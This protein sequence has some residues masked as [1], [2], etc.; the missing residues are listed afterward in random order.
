MDLRNNFIRTKL[1]F[2]E[3]ESGPKDCKLDGD[4]VKFVT[5]T[6]KGF[7]A[8]TRDNWVYSLPTRIGQLPKINV[9]NLVSG[10]EHCLALLE[11]GDVYVWGAGL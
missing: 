6:L 4:H 1:R 5:S 11:N 9:I 7:Y 10:F 3:I 8:I 2:L